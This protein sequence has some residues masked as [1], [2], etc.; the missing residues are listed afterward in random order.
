MRLDSSLTTSPGRGRLRSRP[1]VTWA[2]VGERVTRWCLATHATFGRLVL[3]ALAFGL[4]TRAEEVQL[5]NTRLTIGL[6]RDDRYA[7]SALVDRAANRDF[8]LPRP[9]GVDQDRSPWLI[10]LRSDD[11][12]E[13]VC[14]A[15]DAGVASHTATDGRLTITWGQIKNRDCACDLTVT[16]T[17]RLPTGDVKSYWSISVR[18]KG[19]CSLWQVDF[20]RVFGVTGLGDDQMC[21]PQYWGRLWRNPTRQRKTVR[22]V[23]PQPAS[24]QFVAFWGTSDRREPALPTVDEGVVATGWS[25]DRR[26]A[27]G[28]YWAAEDGAGYLKHFVVETASVPGQLAWHVEN[29]PSLDGWP[30]EQTNPARSFEYASP[31]D[32]AVAVFTG[33]YHEAARLYQDWAAKQVWCQRG[34][35]DEWPD[36]TPPPSGEGL[37]Q[38]IPTWFRRIAFWAKFYHE[39]AKVLPEWGAYRQ[40]LRVP[41]ASHYYRY[42]IS[43]FDDNY[44]EHLPADPYFEQGTRAARALGVRPLPYING[45]IWDTDTQ[46]WQRENGFAAAAKNETGG[47]YPWDING[48]I[49]A[50]MCPATEQWRAKMRETSEKLICEQGVSGVYLDCLAATRTRPCYDPTHGHPIR[51]GNY[52]GQG[53]RKLMHDLRAHIRALDPQ[54][55]FFTEEIGELYIDVMDGYLTLDLTRS[56]NQPGE[57]VFPLFSAVY[58]PYTI[59][60]GSDA[61]LGLPPDVF[62]WQMGTLLTWG[63]QP[64]LSAIVAKPPEA[65]DTNSELLRDMV[66]AYHCA[67]R[68]FLQGGEWT[69]LA[70]RPPDVP[71]GSCGLELSVAPHDMQFSKRRDRVVTWRGPAILAS[72]W[73]RD[74]QVGIVLVNITDT[75]RTGELTVRPAALGMGEGARLLRLWPAPVDEVPL[76][77]GRV[78]L[79][80]P[81]RRTAVYVLQVSRDQSVPALDELDDPAWTLLN[82]V[83]DEFPAV[84]DPA[85]S[86]WACSDALIRNAF[87]DKGTE[88]QPVAL[89]DDGTAL[90][91]HGKQAQR[92]GPSAEGRGLPRQADEQPFLLLRRLP[93]TVAAPP[94]AETLV[95]SGSDSHLCCLASAGTQFRFAAPGWAIVSDALTGKLVRGLAEGTVS[96][97]KLPDTGRYIVGYAQLEAEAVTRRLTSSG[98]L[99]ARGG[100]LTARIAAISSVPPAQRTAALAEAVRA[101]HD[102]QCSLSDAPGALSGVS[103]LTELHDRLQALVVAKTGGWTALTA[104][105]DWVSPGRPKALRFEARSLC[106]AFYGTTAVRCT[107][108]GGWPEGGLTV[109]SPK[110]PESTAEG[111]RLFSPVVTLHDA[112]YVERM[113]PVIAAATVVKDGQEFLLTD[114]LRLTTNRPLEIRGPSTAVTAVAGRR[115]SAEVVL[116]NWSPDAARVELTASGPEGW[117][118]AVDPTGIDIP[119]LRDATVRL[120][121]TPGDDSRRGGHQARCL[122]RYSAVPD[123]EVLAVLDVNLLERLVPLDPGAGEWLPPAPNNV[124][125]HRRSGK[126]A[127]YAE[128]GE[129]LRI[130]LRNI[131][132]TI[133]T[134]TLSYKLFGPGLEQVADGKIAVDDSRSVQ[135]TARESGA[136]YLEVKPGSGSAHVQVSS[137]CVAEIATKTDPLDLFCSRILRHFFVPEG[138]R[139]FRLG[140]RDGGPD[141]T[142]RF[143]VTS[144]TGRVA[145]DLN[146]NFAGNELDVAVHDDEAG[147]LW[148]VLCDP[149]QDVTFWLSGDVCPYLSSSPERVLVGAG[150]K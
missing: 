64:L 57:Q 60:F 28:L 26:D 5:S 79:N 58:H 8:V 23:Y 20:P 24:M 97:V 61:E 1:A 132:V 49:H 27:S 75:D 113:V 17:I 73:K 104:E 120:A 72:A 81:G 33:D 137:R 10:R 62:A 127:V 53:N 50:H 65:G 37:V 9:E 80:V 29:I 71:Q 112:A 86:L 119:A 84:T 55:A 66:Q 99:R 31:Y 52:S 100:P 14:S 40:W 16:V 149:R 128:A 144:P 39:P 63:A 148:T 11:G 135:H 82:V 122:A 41:A 30:Q 125:C 106:A 13:S 143:V 116:R 103:P 19:A 2:C 150:A 45:V 145:L 118:L 141:E 42:N 34:P 94:E 114:V 69:R 117:Q 109:T 129:V 67:A 85:E 32:V 126:L 51:G 105:N 88:A 38:W 87:G 138:S 108:V 136:F 146:G 74:G 76:T 90:P 134:D 25:P 93:V 92:R 70:V 12:R 46:S 96:A 54:A 142:A 98:T 43:R 130:D 44:P 77:A 91:R 115:S 107:A 48:E 18:G 4:C 36:A 7:V 95:L 110:K 21:V 111:L 35:A 6:D 124:S 139:G 89:A 3:A 15:A 123:A 83:D 56:A 102:L 121:L 47:I 133:Y 68:P 140:A 59:N 131:R 78:A 101:L 147:K 22:L